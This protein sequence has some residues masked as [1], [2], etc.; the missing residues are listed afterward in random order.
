MNTQD[1][2][3]DNKINDSLNYL[4]TI[5]CVKC[6]KPATYFGGHV[7]HETNGTDNVIIAGLC[8]EHIE[9]ETYSCKTH[10]KGCFGKWKAEMGTKVYM[11]LSFIHSR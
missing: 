9:A 5:D 4:S 6:G 7:H 1:N 11:E 8:Q 3:Q 10:Q 2:N